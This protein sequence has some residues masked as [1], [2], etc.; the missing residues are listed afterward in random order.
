MDSLTWWLCVVCYLVTWQ[1]PSNFLILVWQRWETNSNGQLKW[2]C[3]GRNEWM[4]QFWERRCIFKLFPPT[5]YE[6]ELGRKVRRSWLINKCISKWDASG[7][8]QG[9]KKHLRFVLRYIQETS[10]G[11][12][13]LFCNYNGTPLGL[14]CPRACSQAVAPH[15]GLAS[16]HLCAGDIEDC[17]FLTLILSSSPVKIK[18]ID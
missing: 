11:C 9:W 12:A 15:V 16:C 6:C 7:F 13:M 10:V 8:W 17:V 1:K 5:S 4:S 3:V 2:L 18:R 14:S